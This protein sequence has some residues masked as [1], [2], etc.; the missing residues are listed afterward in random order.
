M[1]ER[2]GD[3]RRYD[4]FCE[5]IRGAIPPGTAAVL[6]GSAVTGVRHGDHAPFDADGP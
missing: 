6:R 3:P 1:T 4:Q 2:N 5:V